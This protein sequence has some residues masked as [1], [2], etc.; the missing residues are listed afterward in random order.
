MKAYFL[1]FSP[2][3]FLDK[4][5]VASAERGEDGRGYSSFSEIIHSPDE[6]LRPDDDCE[7]ILA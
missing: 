2:L 3:P 6:R 4:P 1:F 7:N 5:S